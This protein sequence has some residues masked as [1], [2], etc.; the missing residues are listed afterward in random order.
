MKATPLNRQLAVYQERR[1]PYNFPVNS[2][3]PLPQIIAIRI[4]QLRIA[5]SHGP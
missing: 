1:T 2:A 3:H 5:W 4:V